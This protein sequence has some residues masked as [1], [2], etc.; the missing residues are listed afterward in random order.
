MAL[1]LTLTAV[2]KRY[3]EKAALQQCSVA[4]DRGG[5]YALMGPNG[6][7]KS[8]L[9]RICALIE[10]ADSGA[11]AYGSGGGALPHELS[12]R[13]R[14]SLVLPRV[15][16]FNASVGKNAAYGL[17]LRGIGKAAIEEKT[18]SVLS[19]VGLLHKK[20]Q[21][22]GTLSSGET[23]RLGLA[24]AMVIE[25]EFLFLDEP[26]ASIDEENT[27]LVEKIILALKQSG[28]TTVVMSTHDRE[29]A[30]RLADFVVLMR[31][32]TITGIEQRAGSTRGKASL[33]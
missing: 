11:V 6:S 5:I 7:G 21:N 19:S 32:G 22:A 29:Q 26:T 16:V 9:L 4:F 23:Q 15:G 28:K 14:I 1:T 25:P 30:A 27:E 12:L 10:T 17:H 13:R 2:S 20:K 3:G 8:T 18:D 24:R 33:S 31:E